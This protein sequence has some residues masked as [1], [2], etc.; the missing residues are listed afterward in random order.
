M[1]NH[2]NSI[3]LSPFPQGSILVFSV[4]GKAFPTKRI[5]GLKWLIHLFQVCVLGILT[6]LLDCDFYKSDE[7]SLRHLH[8]ECVL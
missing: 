7:G 3:G 5:L 1:V 6:H 2:L 8:K 4:V